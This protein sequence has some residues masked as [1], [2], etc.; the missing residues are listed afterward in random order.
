MTRNLI[1]ILGA[2]L[3][4]LNLNCSGILINQR[5]ENLVP[6]NFG[7]KVYFLYKNS[8][9]NYNYALDFLEN[10]NNKRSISPEVLLFLPPP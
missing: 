1:N 10:R 9:G 7:N 3:I 4:S 5:D 8:Q 2:C 6:I